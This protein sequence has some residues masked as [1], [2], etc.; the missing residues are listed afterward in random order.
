M[1]RPPLRRGRQRKKRRR[2]KRRLRGQLC[3][4][5]VERPSEFVS[6]AEHFE[7]AN[8]SGNQNHIS[9][10]YRCILNL[11]LLCIH[12]NSIPLCF[13]GVNPKGKA[14][15]CGWLPYPTTRD[16]RSPV[17]L[18]HMVDSSRW[19]PHGVDLA[20]PA[21]CIDHRR[22]LA[23]GLDVVEHPVPSYLPFV[24]VHIQPRSTVVLKSR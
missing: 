9:P 12:L 11:R 10:R 3:L 1:I 13:I 17:P 7:V 15:L 8:S 23:M 14:R 6:N 2:H 16:L 21:S 20:L 19:R 4:P 24:Y 22:R 18:V 5:K